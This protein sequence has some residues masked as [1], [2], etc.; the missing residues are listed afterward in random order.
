MFS[1]QPP[2]KAS[3]GSYVILE[4][5]G[6]APPWPKERDRFVFL[7]ALRRSLGRHGAGCAGFCLLEGGAHLLLAAPPGEEIRRAV[8][9]ACGAYARYW[10]DWHT[11]RRRVFRPARAAAV[12]RELWWDALAHLETAPVR[13]GLAEAAEDYRWSSA[14]AHAGWGQSYLRLEA[15]E[16]SACWSCRQ[17]RGRLAEWGGD[18]RRLKAVLRLVEGARPLR[19]PGASEREPCPGPL[20]HDPVPAARAVGGGA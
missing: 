2:E 18:L 8:A 9:E 20:F 3:A 10:R 11:G 15:D 14:A 13:A 6:P 5:A 7:A 17:W 19:A 16:W 1:C 12:P 4:G